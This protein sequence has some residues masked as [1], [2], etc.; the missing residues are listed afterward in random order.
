MILGSSALRIWPNVLAALRVAP[1]L[2]NRVLFRRLKASARNSSRS[3]SRIENAR[4][5]A[6]SSWKNLG[7]TTLR[8]PK[9]PYVPRAGCANAG[10]WP[11]TPAFNQLMQDAVVTLGHDVPLL[12]AKMSP[13][14]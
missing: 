12:K 10:A 6:T 9:F 1:G 11:L 8:T 5:K 2:L 4:T 13:L 3:P 7:P 14:I